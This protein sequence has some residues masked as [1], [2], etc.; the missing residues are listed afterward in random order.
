MHFLQGLTCLW[1]IHL[2][3]FQ[4]PAQEHENANILGQLVYSDMSVDFDHEPARVV[5]ETIEHQLGLL[6]NVV[7]EEEDGD[8]GIDPT[9]LVTYTSKQKPALQ[10]LEQIVFRLH[11]EG[12]AVWQLRHGALE[13]GLKQTLAVRG[14]QRIETYYIRDLLFS[15]RN[16]SAPEL[17]TFGGDDGDSDTQ[18]ETIEE[19]IQKTLNLIVQFIEPEMWEQGGGPCTISSYKKTLLIRAPDFMHRQINGYNFKP[20]QPK[21]VRERRVLYQKDKTKIIVDRLPIR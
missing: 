8:G 19:E 17:G 7:W 4:A 18:D 16:F 2:L 13:I 21:Q 10:V 1:F 5:L 15:I 6:M 12:E 3:S 9:I 20:R 14:R 11:E